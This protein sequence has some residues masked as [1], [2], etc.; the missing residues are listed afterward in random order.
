MLYTRFQMEK[1]QGGLYNT[2][3][4]SLI[5]K[6][7]TGTTEKESIPLPF[8]H[9]NAKPVTPNQNTFLLFPIFY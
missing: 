9:V 2:N 3:N 4:A 5:S 6:Y 1:H 7:R 8:L